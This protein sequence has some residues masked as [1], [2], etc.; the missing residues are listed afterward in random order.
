MGMRRIADG[1]PGR[2]RGTGLHLGTVSK[3]VESLKKRGLLRA[4]PGIRGRLSY[5]IAVHSLQND[6]S[7]IANTERSEIANSQCSEIPNMKKESRLQKESVKESAKKR[8]AALS[9]KPKPETPKGNFEPDDDLRPE[10]FASTV[11]WLQAIVQRR[12]GRLLEVKT[13]WKIQENLSGARRMTEVPLED[14]V[15]YVKDGHLRGACGSP[16]AVLIRLSRGYGRNTSSPPQLAP[17]RAIETPKCPRCHCAP[18]KGLVLK[19]DGSGFEAC[20]ACN[21][22]E[23]LEQQERERQERRRAASEATAA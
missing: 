8:E 12:T 22:P 11:D 18:G 9:E 17:E 4:V 13:I 5:E 21:T 14:F 20:P 23:A 1:I 2:D 15:A 6:C 19:S 3:A 16:D 7:E 10:R